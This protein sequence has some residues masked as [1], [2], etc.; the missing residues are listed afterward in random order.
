VDDKQGADLR[1]VCFYFKPPEDVSFGEIVQ[2]AL[3]QTA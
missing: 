1:K 2:E 3:E